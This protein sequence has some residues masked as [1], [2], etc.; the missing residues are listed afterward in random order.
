MPS[1]LQVI[2]DSKVI[3]AKAGIYIIFIVLAL[4]TRFYGIFWGNL[5]FFHPDENNMA[6]ALAQLSWP[7]NLNPHFF[8]YGQFPLYLGYF[9]L[10]L[11]HIANSFPSSIY[12][13]RIWS[14][15]FSVATII[16]LY[17]LS[18]LL[19]KKYSLLLPLL[20]VFSPG[21]IQL[22]HFGTT[23]SLLIF[24]S[25]TVVYLA[26]KYLH[27]PQ[28]KY[29]LGSTLLVGIGFGSKLTALFFAA[30][31]LLAILFKNVNYKFFL[32]AFIFSLSALLIALISSP[33]SLIELAN[34]KSAMLYETGVA[35]GL[36][37]VFYTNQFLH[38]T[39]YL[40]PLLH[41]F[42]YALG[43]P[44]FLL[45]IFGSFY[46]LIH[47]SSLINRKSII[48]LI[49]SLVYFIYNGQLYT[50][51][52][53]FM[54]PLFV[55]LLFPVALFLQTIISKNKKLGFGLL[56]LCLLP[57]LLF[58]QLYFQPDI[59]LS[60]SS[61]INTHFPPQSIVLSEAGNVAN[62]PIPNPSLAVT[63]FDF[64]NLD[65]NPNL[66]LDLVDAISSSEYILIPSRR[67]FMNQQGPTFP[68]SQKYY[69]NL[70]N[71]NLGFQLVKE[72]KPNTDFLLPG[73]QAEETFT[74]F[75]HPTIRLYQ[76]VKTLTLAQISQLILK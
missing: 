25:V 65:T 27:H 75:D 34:F 57:G 13:L 40:F 8:A 71:G 35:T 76:K 22:A 7:T 39:P 30:P 70:F 66:P 2:P 58:M 72:F 43:L 10:R 37:K 31:I 14:A 18:Q 67:I 63:N 23:E 28:L 3:P 62:I 60:A 42:P 47:K 9:S 29:V 52:F 50:K 69:Q 20:A 21:L 5:N 32:L 49:P 46:F 41:I 33:Y 55:F 16:I 24:V 15:L 56:G 54:S 51:W 4:F 74:V 38:T 44:A 68:I 12:V 61:W 53:R 26:Q 19:F 64:Y 36:I 1:K 59:R 11:F 45:F 48:I 6:T 73:E 17:R